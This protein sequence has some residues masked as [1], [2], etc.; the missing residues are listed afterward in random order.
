MFA[1]MIDPAD[2]RRWAKEVGGIRVAPRYQ[3]KDVM[4][5]LD[6]FKAMS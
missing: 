6:L 2:V 1:R 5:C 4:K 3:R